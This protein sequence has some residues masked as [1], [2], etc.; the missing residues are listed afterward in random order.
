MSNFPWRRYISA[1]VQRSCVAPMVTRGLVEVLQPL[2]RPTRPPITVRKQPE[3]IRHRH[4]RSCGA[5]GGQAF[6]EQRQA[7]FRAA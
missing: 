3:E 7:F 5:V 4:E 6:R 2:F 1:S